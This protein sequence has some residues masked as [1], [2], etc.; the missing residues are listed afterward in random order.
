MKVKL[1][2]FFFGFFGIVV[3]V[4]VKE[5]IYVNCEVIIYIVMFENIK[6]VDIFIIKIMGNQCV[7]NMVCI[8]FYLE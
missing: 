7:D 2:L 8:K 6:L 5:K 1:F 4:V 3:Q